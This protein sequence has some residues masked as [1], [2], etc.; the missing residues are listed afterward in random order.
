MERCPMCG[1]EYPGQL[2][3]V[4]MDCG[5]QFEQDH[6]QPAPPSP[7]QAGLFAAG[8]APPRP[9]DAMPSAPGY[10]VTPAPVIEAKANRF[11]VLHTRRARIVISAALVLL[12]VAGVSAGAVVAISSIKH[13]S[14]A[15][16]TAEAMRASVSQAQ[17]YLNSS[18]RQLAAGKDK[19]API[20]SATVKLDTV[21]KTV[22]G[23]ERLL[24]T[25]R[26]GVPLTELVFRV[27]ANSPTVSPN[28]NAA[29]ITGVSAAGLP[30]T[31]TLVGSLLHVPLTATLGAGK[32]TLLT[33]TFSEGIPEVSGGIDISQLMGG[34][35]ASGYGVFGHSTDIYDLGYFLPTVTTYGPGGWDSREAP[36]FGD[37]SNFDC[38]YYSVSIDVPSDYVVAAAGMPMGQGGSGGRETYDFRGGPMRD[39][40]VQ[41]SPNYQTASASVGETAVTAYFLKATPDVGGQVLGFARDA[42]AQY[43]KH[44]GSYPYRRFNVCEAPLGGGAGGMEFAGQVQIAQMLYA[45]AGGL[46]L[47]QGSLLGGIAGGLGDMLEFTVAH[48]VCHQW[49]GLVVG[50]DS[51]EHPWQDESL[52]NYCTV[53]YFGWQHGAESAQQQ[54]D[55]ELMLSYSTAKMLGAPDMVV[56]SP[57][58]AFKD[59]TVYSAIVYSKGALFFQALQKNMGEQAFDKSLS[60]YYQRYSFGNPTPDELMACFE[61]NGN[62]TTIAALDTRWIHELHA[63]EDIPVTATANN[64]LNNLMQQLG[65]SG[66]DMNQLN[67]LMKQ[68]LPEGTDLNELLKQLAPNGTMPQ[69][70]GLDQQPGQQPV[71]PF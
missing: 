4:C 57:V 61:S 22:S 1:K 65:D 15:P 28:G 41:A 9:P 40:S 36:A 49:W 7:G 66:I 12:L 26:T 54:V 71:L 58:Y 46:N 70:P 33:M 19:S 32:D 8:Q 50:S 69:I 24:Y 18:G 45:G 31:P 51:I 6:P 68:Y 37:V 13:P 55:S 59:Q 64:L 62:A 38:A 2:P 44:F 35:T 27:Y 5:W 56:D 14:P 42:L 43:N 17:G 53:L 52:T 21:A 34:T 20:Y 30:A 67:D 39:F 48:E 16:T 25:N 23:T 29:T 63:N 11:P 10:Y 3:R 60:D 47:G